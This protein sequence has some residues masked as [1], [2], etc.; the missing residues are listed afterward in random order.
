M[1]MCR[2]LRANSKNDYLQMTRRQEHFKSAVVCACVLC[3]IYLYH[4]SLYLVEELATRYCTIGRNAGTGV[5]D[6]Q[7]CFWKIAECPSADVRSSPLDELFS[8]IH[9][10]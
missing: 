4:Y 6:I 3:S 2:L 5:F 8:N 10:S 1:V 9:L 7:F